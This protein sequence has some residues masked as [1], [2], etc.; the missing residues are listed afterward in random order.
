MK[1]KNSMTLKEI[2]LKSMQWI[3]RLLNLFLWFRKKRIIL[4]SRWQMN[5]SQQWNSLGRN[6]S[7]K[8]VNNI[9]KV[10]EGHKDI[11]KVASYFSCVCIPLLVS[12]KKIFLNY[13]EGWRS[14]P[15]LNLR[16]VHDPAS[17]PRSFQTP[18]SFFQL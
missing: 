4:R 11:D 17:R 13:F 12:E 10:A 14:H 8:V 2:Y 7:R 3:L 6:T 9:M 1:D 5:N 18:Y 16:L 15:I